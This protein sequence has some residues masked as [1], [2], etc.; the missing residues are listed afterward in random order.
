MKYIKKIIL[1][2]LISL[3]ISMISIL[4]ISY[5]IKNI[6][7]D[8]IIKET[9]QE[10]MAD[11]YQEFFT[12]DNELINKTLDSEEMHNII[13]KYINIMIDCIIVEN[14]SCNIEI[15]K[16]INNYFENN[17]ETIKQ[18][19][20]IDDEQLI[21]ETIARSLEGKDLS[22][23]IKQNINNTKNN[24]SQEEKTAIKIYNNIIKDSFRNIIF[25]MII[26][27]ILL[28]LIIKKSLLKTISSTGSSLLITGLGYIIMSYSIDYI[29]NKELKSNHF[30]TKQLFDLGI[31]ITIIGI[32]IVTLIIIIEK[33]IK[34][35]KRV[36]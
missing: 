36:E 28:I 31:Y 16:D 5:N 35:R 4:G 15:E 27:D 2:L 20:G 25:I 34:I 8:G 6:I 24:L 1:F 10:E 11:N 26:V 32:I 29:I 9:I 7:I 21:L 22:N 33:I 13:N 17:I 19:L 14:S 18:T 12:S 30:Y 23:S 3:L